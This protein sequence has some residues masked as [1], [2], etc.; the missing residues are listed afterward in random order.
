[1]NPLESIREDLTLAEEEATGDYSYALVGDRIEV[2]PWTP[3]GQLADP[4]GYLTYTPIE[5]TP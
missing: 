4:I 1:M 3:E 2:I 5:V